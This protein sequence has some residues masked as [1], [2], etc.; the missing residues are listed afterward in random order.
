MRVRHGI[1]SLMPLQINKLP[2]KFTWRLKDKDMW[3]LFWPPKNDHR[4]GL[5]DSI[6]ASTIGLLACSASF[7]PNRLN[8]LCAALTL[9]FT[10]FSRDPNLTCKSTGLRHCAFPNVLGLLILNAK[11]YNM[12]ISKWSICSSYCS[13][14]LRC[15]SCKKRQ[16]LL[17]EVS[18]NVSAGQHQNARWD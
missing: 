3:Y 2:L 7:L 6:T 1:Q 14:K 12:I 15:S 11:L 9:V 8:N 16:V 18:Y 4:P 5:G 17:L 10:S 13:R